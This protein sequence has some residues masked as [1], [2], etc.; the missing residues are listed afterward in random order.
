MEFEIKMKQ[1]SIDEAVLAIK[2]QLKKDEKTL[3]SR[4]AL[5]GEI[6]QAGNF[7]LTSRQRGAGLSQFIGKLVE[8]DENIYLKG[9]ILL[10]NKKMK[11]FLIMMIFNGIFGLLLIFSGNPLFMLVGP[12][13]ITLPWVNVWIAKRGNYLKSSLNIIFSRMK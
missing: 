3:L 4:N 12:V 10:N 5:I 1:Q 2:A 8:E 9:E 7:N 6:D 13:F 11:M